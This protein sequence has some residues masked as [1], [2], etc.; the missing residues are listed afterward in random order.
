MPNAIAFAM[1]AIW[2]FVVMYLFARM[3]I[4]KAFVCA[5]IAGYLVLPPLP[6]A[7]DLRFLPPFDKYSI[8]HLSL[9]VAIMF[10][11][12]ARKDALPLKVS[13]KLARPLPDHFLG[14]IL[15]ILFIV[16]P[17]VTVLTNAEPLVF[18]QLVIR[19][20]RF[21]DMIALPI[22]QAMGLTGYLLARQYLG[23]SDN[24][25]FV[26]SALMVAGLIYS[27]PI[28]VEIRLSPQLNLWIYGF[29]QHQFDQV[30]RGG[31]FRPIVFLSH[32]IWVAFFIMT[33]AIAALTLWRAKNTDMRLKLL[34]AT[35]YLI[36]ILVL[37]KTLAPLL[38][39]ILLAPL[40][41]FVTAKTQIRIAVLL[42]ILAFT[43][44]LL[45]GANLVPV[46]LLLTQASKIDPERA[47]SLKFRF[48]NEE[49]LAERVAEKPLFGWGSWGRNQ[50]H[51]PVSGEITSV[52]DGRWIIVIGK[53]GWLG[54]I[55]EFGLLLLPLILIWRET[56]LSNSEKISPYIG[57]L[58]LILAVNMIDLLPN[59]TLTPITWIIAGGLL[60]YA[61]KQ[62]KERLNA[63]TKSTA[64]VLASRTLI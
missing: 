40:V 11:T 9:V 20:L 3:P 62:R 38:F 37:S 6:A 30:I 57:P 12:S 56:S 2:P 14:K 15:V 4:A 55:A 44:P 26:L 13:Q 58:S 42:A 28:L 36:G 39:V 49:I 64:T 23:A 48:D 35:V 33:S 43:Y 7:F 25:R 51:D 5:V 45:K 22:I 60:G 32:S 31:G 46:N 47:A 19:G 41:M 52:S 34:I 59:A 18:Q 29:F 8:S 16:S 27:L 1:L 61:E 17:I 50:I 54:Y 53:F 63:K 21:S 10:A 24:L